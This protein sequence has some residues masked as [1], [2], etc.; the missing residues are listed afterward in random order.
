VKFPQKR[1]NRREEKKGREGRRRRRGYADPRCRRSGPRSGQPP[2]P[3]GHG[4]GLAGRGS[5]SSEFFFFFFFLMDLLW[6]GYGFLVFS[7]V[8]IWLQRLLG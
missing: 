5:C 1:K 3:T 7:L 6:F 2:R 8:F 4:L